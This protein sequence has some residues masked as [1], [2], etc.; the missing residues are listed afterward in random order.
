MWDDGDWSVCLSRWPQL[1]RSL[2]HATR[3]QHSEK[4][5]MRIRKGSSCAFMCGA[6]RPNCNLHFTACFDVSWWK[7]LPVK[8]IYVCHAVVNNHNC[9]EVSACAECSSTQ[10]HDN[11]KMWTHHT[12]LTLAWHY[13]H[14]RQHPWA[15]LP[16]R[17]TS[18][19]LASVTT[20]LLYTSDAADE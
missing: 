4:C 20:C 6:C 14:S 17:P 13:R 16:P 19:A 5:I 3:G 7:M 1:F 11:E 12:E 10:F 9:Q 2:P 15:E 8:V 18:T